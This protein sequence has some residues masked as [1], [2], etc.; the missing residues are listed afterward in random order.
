LQA[1]RDSMAEGA[2]KFVA[3]VNSKRPA[4]ERSP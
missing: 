2:R 1:M 3:Y 4:G